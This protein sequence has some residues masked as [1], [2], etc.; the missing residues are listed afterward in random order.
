[1]IMN[2]IKIW[3]WNPH[4]LDRFGQRRLIEIAHSAHP[5]KN[6]SPWESTVTMPANGEYYNASSKPLP[7]ISGTATDESLANRGAGNRPHYTTM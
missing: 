7:M 1:M 6:I 4:P 3:W 2:P 5:P